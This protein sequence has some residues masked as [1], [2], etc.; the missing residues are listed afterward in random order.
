MAAAAAL[1]LSANP[2]LDPATVEWL[3]AR[4]ARIAGGDFGAVGWDQNFG[5]GLPRLDT[6]IRLAKLVGPG[7]L[8][9][10]DFESG[11]IYWSGVT[12]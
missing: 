11:A 12:P 9:F 7:L 5:W 3:L 4:S 10:D 1:V 8:F 2:A 6:A